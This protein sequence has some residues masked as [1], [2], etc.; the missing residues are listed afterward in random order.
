MTLRGGVLF[1]VRKRRQSSEH[2]T[3]FQKLVARASQIVARLQS[4]SIPVLMMG[5]SGRIGSVA[6]P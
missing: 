5:D 4:R 2:I 1:P 3:F 6:G